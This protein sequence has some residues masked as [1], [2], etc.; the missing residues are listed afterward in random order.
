M[1]SA[2]CVSIGKQSDPGDKRHQKEIKADKFIPKPN[3]KQKDQQKTQSK[4]IGTETK[5][6]TEKS[7]MENR[8]IPSE[9]K[10]TEGKKAAAKQSRKQKGAKGQN[11]FTCCLEYFAWTVRCIGD[12]T[13]QLTTSRVI[14][15]TFLHRMAGY[16]LCFFPWVG[17][18][19]YV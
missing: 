13:A 14:R 12:H 9:K 15:S 10:K 6:Q 4:H 17:L 2:T 7:T 19:D 3:T 11:K 16:F 5:D 8:S 1:L 18:W